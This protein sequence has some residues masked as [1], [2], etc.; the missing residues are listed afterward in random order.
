M[1]NCW[2]GS[3]AVLGLALTHPSSFHLH[4]HCRLLFPILI[5]GSNSVVNAG[6]PA[7]L[8]L[9]TLSQVKEGQKVWEEWLWPGTHRAKQTVMTW[10]CFA[11]THT[12]E[13]C[14]DNNNPDR[15]T[16]CAWLSSTVLYILVDAF[17]Y[18]ISTCSH[19]N[20][21]AVGTAWCPVMESSWVTG[22]NRSFIPVAVLF[23][24]GADQST[25]L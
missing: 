22:D 18:G 19:V 13:F 6:E 7:Y 17:I 4:P 25:Y 12:R 9:Q 2:R 16:V 5:M 23:H 11:T 21:G 1:T 3:F 15:N 14:R 24:K 20:C 8:T 10:T